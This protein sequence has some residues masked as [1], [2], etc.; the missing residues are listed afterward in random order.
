[1]ADHTYASRIKRLGVPD[2]FIE[3]GGT[4]DLLKECGFDPE[5]ITREVKKLVG[6][7]ILLT[8]QN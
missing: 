2:K 8:S 4:M 5:S 1:M 3:Q 6:K 7:K